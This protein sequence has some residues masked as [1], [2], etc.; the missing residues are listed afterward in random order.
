[1]ISALGFE[2]LVLSPRSKN[3]CSNNFLKVLW[4]RISYIG[5]PTPEFYTEGHENPIYFILV[6]M[7]FI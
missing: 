2:K 4:I 1:M 3:M 6:L 5:I 7:D